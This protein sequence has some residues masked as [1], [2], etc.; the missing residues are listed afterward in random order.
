MLLKIVL[1]IL[2]KQILMK[3][4]TIAL[5]LMIYKNIRTK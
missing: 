1:K 2:G 3:Y 5:M 4:W